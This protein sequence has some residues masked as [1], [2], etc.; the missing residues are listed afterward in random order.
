MAGFYIFFIN[1]SKT[2]K[3]NNI[4]FEV[5]THKCGFF[6]CLSVQRTKNITHYLKNTW[7]ECLLTEIHLSFIKKINWR[8]LIT[9]LPSPHLLCGS[10]VPV[11]L[12]GELNEARSLS[13]TQYQEKGRSTGITLS[14]VHSPSHLVQD[15]PFLT[16]FPSHSQ[17]P[18]QGEGSVQMW[19]VEAVY[20][21]CYFFFYHVY[22]SC[23]YICVGFSWHTGGCQDEVR[24]R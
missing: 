12:A 11:E 5:F 7:I 2:S 6:I 18:W 8:I 10:F 3:Q 19:W 1:A 9:T 22:T 20:M 14:R 23:L 24:C 15:F 17:T 4:S 16:C 13:I 21:Y